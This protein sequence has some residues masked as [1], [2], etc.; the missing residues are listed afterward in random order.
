M[1][2]YLFGSL[3]LLGPLMGLRAQNLVP[4]HGFELH[5]KSPQEGRLLIAN[6]EGWYNANQRRKTTLY[7]T[8]DHM[9]LPPTAK[10]QGYKK[11]FRPYAGNSSL[12]LILYMKRV[13]NYR[14]F[15]SVKLLQPMVK[16]EKYRVS[17][18][19]SNGYTDTFGS[20]GAS[21]LG[22]C[23]TPQPLQQYRYEPIGCKPQY[24]MDEILYGMGWKKF[25][26]EF[27]ADQPHQYLTVGNFRL[28]NQ[29]QVKEFKQDVDPQCYIYLDEVVVVP[30]ASTDAVAT[31]GAPPEQPLEQAPK[32]DDGTVGK[33]VDGRQVQEQYRFSA[34]QDD[35]LVRVWDDKVEDG[36]VISLY[37]NGEW[38]LKDYPLNLYKKQIRIR[39]REGA[40]NRLIMYAHNLGSQPPNTAAIQLES[41]AFR[42]VI[43]LMS[44]LGMC[45]A[46]Q[47]SRRP[48]AKP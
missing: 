35:I 46:V 18:Y 43:S 9:Y 44:D 23:F 34:T 36:D 11:L 31:Q 27:A 25:T 47:I 17:F 7:G 12:G 21:G 14:E 37:F 8:P 40:D 15:A 22:F 30:A 3:L 13:G 1:K 28:D 48:K 38:V 5:K 33:A 24:E 41:G 6:L 42:Q 19:A 2:R 26:F 4:N 10:L 29:I 20:M 45:G 32:P 16:G 39:Y